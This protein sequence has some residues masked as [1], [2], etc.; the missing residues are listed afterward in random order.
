MSHE[1]LQILYKR[2]GLT[3]DMY[4]TKKRITLL[5]VTRDTTYHETPY[6]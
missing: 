6:L 5:P 4:I 1:I 3:N 2:S